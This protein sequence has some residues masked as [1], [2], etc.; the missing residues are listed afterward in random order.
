VAGRKNA[1]ACRFGYNRPIVGRLG[2]AS[3][4]KPIHSMSP[5]PAPQIHSAEEVV[6]LAN[7]RFYAAFESLDLAQMEAVWSHDDSVECVQPG[8]DLLL[9]WDEVRERWAR[10]FANTSRVRVALSGVRVRVEGS[11]GWVACTARVTTAFPEGFD[12]AV[13][14]AT[15]I[16]VLREGEWLLAAH[17]ASILPVAAESESTVQ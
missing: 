6:R 4:P 11:V 9:G 15:N 7:R 16:F 3:L 8:W 12:E 1:I 2:V 5:Q 14:Q 13:V 17:H 10:V